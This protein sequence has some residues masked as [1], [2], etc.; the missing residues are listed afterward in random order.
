MEKIILIGGGGHCRSVIDVLEQTSQYSIAGIVDIPS[1]KNT[2]VE[3][4]PVIGCDSDL[5]Q[6]VKNTTNF[7]ITLGFVKWPNKRI[8]LYTTLKQLGARLAV[9]ISP[10]AYVSPRAWIAPG[11]VIMHGAIVNTHAHIGP[12]TI[13]NSRALIEH[14]AHIGAHCHISTASVINGGC[15]IGDNVLVGSGSIIKQGL[16]IT[17]GCI[18]GMGS[19]VR[20]SIHQPGIYAGNPF[21]QLDKG[22]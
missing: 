11:T 20:K 21:Q 13:V 12:N 1:K 5:P 2:M 22:K 4:Y 8:K 19:V 10:R 16:K 14:D 9:V 3:G 7:L 18:I 15:I 17:S 6:L